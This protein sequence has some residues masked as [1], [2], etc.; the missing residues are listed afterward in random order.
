[1]QM[2][3]IK[4]STA[5]F[6]E[7]AVHRDTAQAQHCRLLDEFRRLQQHS[8]GKG[9][10]TSTPTIAPQPSKKTRHTTAF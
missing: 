1:M 3:R 2:Q 4:R 7:T 6:P 9:A 10:I 5:D 8:L